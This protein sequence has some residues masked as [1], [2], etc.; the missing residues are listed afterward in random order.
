MQAHATVSDT[1]AQ[2]HTLPPESYLYSHPLYTQS[3]L[4]AHACVTLIR[5]GVLP[6]G[7]KIA[8]V[9]AQ[10]ISAIRAACGAAFRL[11]D[12]SCRNIQASIEAGATGV[13][14]TPLSPIPQ[15]FPSREIVRL[16][17]PEVGPG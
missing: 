11:W 16:R 4:D 15:D 3:R 5:A 13:V 8:K 6:A 10:D 1:V 2:M 14:A 17:P 7:A 12:G 9:G